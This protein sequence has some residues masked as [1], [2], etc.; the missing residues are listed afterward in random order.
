MVSLISSSAVKSLSNFSLISL[1]VMVM[2]TGSGG[3]AVR[4]SGTSAVG[5]S[6]KLEERV[7][8]RCELAG[9]VAAYQLGVSKRT[10]YRMVMVG[11]FPSPVKVSGSSRYLWADLFAV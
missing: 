8:L 3:P 6:Y 11:D 9:P 2:A 5:R 1:S 4:R 10:F 7:K